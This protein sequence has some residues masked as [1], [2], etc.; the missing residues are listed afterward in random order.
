ML[1][2]VSLSACNI[3]ITNPITDE[4]RTRAEE[5]FKPTTLTSSLEQILLWHQTNQTYI[6]PA[7]NPGIDEAAIQQK[8]ADLP[9]QPTEELIELWAWHNG[10]D[11]VAHPFIWYHNFLSVEEAIA[12]YESL[13][14]NPL[15]GWPEHWIPI[16]EFEG[17]WYFVECYEQPRQ[18]SPVGFFFLEDPDAIYAYSSLTKMLETSATWF[19]RNAVTWNSDQQGMEEDLKML[20][21]IHQA[22][23][24]GAQ[25]PYYVE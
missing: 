7:L 14:A 5:T 3:H 13:T 18:A 1:I 23:N 24:E 21:E 4:H 12:E 11:D 15:I 9:C 8:F 2:V 16:F 20:F 19:N 6:V 10:T 17:E 25:F 22:L